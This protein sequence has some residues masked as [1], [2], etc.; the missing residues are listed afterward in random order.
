MALEKIKVRN[1]CM[2]KIMIDLKTRN[3]PWIVSKLLNLLQIRFWYKQK[4]LTFKWC[5]KLI[6]YKHKHSSFLFYVRG[7]AWMQL[8]LPSTKQIDRKIML[9]KRF[10]ILF[11]FSSS[12]QAKILKADESIWPQTLS[13]SCSP[14]NN[15]D[16]E[17]HLYH[18]LPNPFRNYIKII[19]ELQS[20]ALPCTVL[21]LVC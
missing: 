1:I 12:W 14:E 3:L 21:F 19:R 5:T 16:R 20:S 15:Y 9:S 8:T 11:R 2:A 7:V 10:L 17:G 13:C 18:N 6:S 4:Y